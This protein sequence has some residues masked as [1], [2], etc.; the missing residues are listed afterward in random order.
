[1]ASVQPSNQVAVRVGNTFSVSAV[2]PGTTGPGQATTFCVIITFPG[3][4]YAAPPNVL[5]TS[6]SVH[7]IASPIWIETNRFGLCVDRKTPPASVQSLNVY[8]LIQGI[9]AST[10]AE[11]KAIDCEVF[12]TP[13]K[14]LDELLRL[15][16]MFA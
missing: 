10:V 16:G 6:A 12:V 7:F 1:M 2:L 5:L 14:D 11:D 13:V 4:P 8:M 9:L 15:G 3:I